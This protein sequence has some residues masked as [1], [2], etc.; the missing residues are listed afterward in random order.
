[1]LKKKKLNNVIVK[2]NIPVRTRYNTTH[3]IIFYDP[4]THNSYSWKT[5]TTEAL[6]YEP[7]EL[8]SITY[9]DEGHNNISH[10]EMIE[11]DSFGSPDGSESEQTQQD[12]MDVLLGLTHYDKK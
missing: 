10:V 12:A 4:E 5:A 9:I 8:Y 7:H 1:M 3:V 2:H 11:N 6:N